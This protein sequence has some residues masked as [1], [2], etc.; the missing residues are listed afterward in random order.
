MAVPRDALV[1]RGGA[2]FVFKVTAEGTAEQ[3]P[4]D[5]RRTVGMWVGID[6]GIEPGDQVIIRGAERLAPGQAVEIITTT[7]AN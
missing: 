3:I 6:Q 1:Q 5:L 2:A 4:A 7:A